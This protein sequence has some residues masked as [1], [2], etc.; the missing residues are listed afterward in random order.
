M[1]TQPPGLPAYP[2]GRIVLDWPALDVREI[3]GDGGTP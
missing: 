3:F 2:A 1:I